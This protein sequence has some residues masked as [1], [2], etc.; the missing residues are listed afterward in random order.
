MS[1]LSAA[2]DAS[3]ALCDDRDM[4]RAAGTVRDY[5]EAHRRRERELE[6]EERRAAGRALESL[7]ELA[8]ML[9]RDFGALRVGYFGSLR[10]GRLRDSSDVD[11]FVDRLRRGH[12]F[13]AVDRLSTALGRPVDLVEIER[14]PPSLIRRIEEDGVDLHG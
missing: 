10:T 6:G 1:G 5:A 13:D 3:R 14:A 4:R 11:L 2:L 12:Y 9:R 8:S 7:A